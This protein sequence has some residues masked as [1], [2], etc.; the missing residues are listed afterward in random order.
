MC[1]SLWEKLLGDFVNAVVLWLSYSLQTVVIEP[2]GLSI[3]VWFSE[4]RSCLGGLVCS[5][6]E[7]FFFLCCPPVCLSR[8]HVSLRR[9]HPPDNRE[10]FCFTEVLT[11]LCQMTSSNRNMVTKSECCCDGGRGWGTNCELCPLPGTTQY[12]RM[13]PLGPGY[14]TDGRGIRLLKRLE[15]KLNH[16]DDLLIVL[17]DLHDKFQLTSALY[18]QQANFSVSNGSKCLH[19]NASLCQLAVFYKAPDEN[20]KQ[21]IVQGDRLAQQVSCLC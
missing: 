1:W 9:S 16:F 8:S 20:I 15:F 5:L 10:G 21:W 18:R 3:Y 17:H 12:K 7:S 4:A 2:C 13:C 6:Q 11:T 14:T 19:W